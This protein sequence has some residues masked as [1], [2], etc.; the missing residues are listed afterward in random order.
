MRAF[1]APQSV[2]QSDLHQKQRAPQRSSV[3]R[4]PPL[5]LSVAQPNPSVAN[6]LVPR[7][8]VSLRKGANQIVHSRIGIARCKW[9]EVKPEFERLQNRNGF[10]FSVIDITVACQWRDD[11]SRDTNTCATT[12]V[13]HRRRNMVPAAAILIVR[14]NN[15]ARVPDIAVLNSPHNICDVLL[16][17]DDIGIAGMLIIDTGEFDE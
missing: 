6:S 10:V 14:K 2:C 12:V 11:N 8:R 17:S 7:L 9:R 1:R 15:R 4:R 3:P 16:S 13:S 5:G